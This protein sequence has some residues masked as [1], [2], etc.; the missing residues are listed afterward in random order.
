MFHI[1]SESTPEGDQRISGSIKELPLGLLFAA[2]VPSVASPE[3]IAAKQSRPEIRKWRR[4]GLKKLN[5]CPEM[6]WPPRNPKVQHE[7]AARRLRM[8]Q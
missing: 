7:G 6:V 2:C 5:S 3:R 8:R 1:C 4:K